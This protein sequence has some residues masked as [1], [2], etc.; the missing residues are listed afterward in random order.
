[1]IALHRPNHEQ[2]AFGETLLLGMRSLT[3]LFV[4][5]AIVGALFLALAG[6]AAAAAPCW[7]R[8]VLAWWADGTVDKTYPVACYHQAISHLQPD[9][10]LYSSASDD[11]RRALQAVVTTNSETATTAPEP[12]T[13]APTTTPEPTTTPAPTPTTETPTTPTT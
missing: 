1:T 10:K 12:T 7:K 11:I 3:S 2:T 4:R 6:P 9:L 13:P 8:V 5:L